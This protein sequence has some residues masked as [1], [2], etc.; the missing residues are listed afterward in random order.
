MTVSTTGEINLAH[1]NAIV[2][3]CRPTINISEQLKAFVVTAR[4]GVTVVQIL[5]RNNK[6][7]GKYVAMKD[8]GEHT[9]V[10]S[11]ST[12][13]EAYDKAVKKG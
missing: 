4:G 6:Y 3:N 8:F 13:T 1:S 10:S 5:T 12:P 7:T 9:I 2:Y 11:G